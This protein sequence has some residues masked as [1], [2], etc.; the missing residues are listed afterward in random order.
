MP[1]KYTNPQCES[2]GRHATLSTLSQKLESFI[3]NASDNRL[4]VSNAI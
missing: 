4:G 1:F 3:G 2:I